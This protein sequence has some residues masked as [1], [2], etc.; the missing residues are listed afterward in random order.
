MSALGFQL[1]TDLIGWQVGQQC[2]GFQILRHGLWYAL[3]VLK[4]EVGIF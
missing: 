1:M 4:G 3:G 2:Q